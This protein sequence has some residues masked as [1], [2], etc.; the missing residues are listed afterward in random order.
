MRLNLYL[1]KEEHELIKKAAKER[2]VS[3]S[4]YTVNEACGW[5]VIIRK[6]K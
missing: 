1:S 2:R 3:M 4:R 5:P 6:K